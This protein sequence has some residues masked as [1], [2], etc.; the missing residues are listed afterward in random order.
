MRLYDYNRD[1]LKYQ[2]VQMT[3]GVL[4]ADVEVCSLAELACFHIEQTAWL[5]ILQLYPLRPHM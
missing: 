3:I 5:Q 1:T 4:I 2:I